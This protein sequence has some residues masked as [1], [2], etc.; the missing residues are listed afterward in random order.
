[1]VFCEA[2]MSISQNEFGFIR[3]WVN[4]YN[5]IIE[6]HVIKAVDNEKKLGVCG[7]TV[8]VDAAKIDN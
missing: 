3:G 4:W 7:K 2:A 5:F 8:Q 1:M 6:V